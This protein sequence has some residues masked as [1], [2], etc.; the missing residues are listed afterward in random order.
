MVVHEF[1]ERRL[2]RE[3]LSQA[4]DVAHAHE[5]PH[6]AAQ[7]TQEIERLT[8]LSMKR[9]AEGNAIVSSLTRI[10]FRAPLY[11]QRSDSRRTAARC[12]VQGAMIFCVLHIG[13]HSEIEQQCGDFKQIMRGGLHE[14]SGVEQIIGMLFYQQGLRTVPRRGS[15]RAQAVDAVSVFAPRIATVNGCPRRTDP[16]WLCVA[17]SHSGYTRAQGIAQRAPAGRCQ[18]ESSPSAPP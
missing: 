2:A 14:G 8:L 4:L 7:S 15:Q 12:G 11:Q 9:P 17:G 16:M 18:E 10:D 5:R 1:G 3:Q 6:V 13:G